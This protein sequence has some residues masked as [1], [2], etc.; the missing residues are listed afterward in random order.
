LFVNSFTCS[1]KKATNNRRRTIEEIRT[2]K[3]HKEIQLL[4]SSKKKTIRKSFG[5]RKGTI[6]AGKPMFVERCYRQVVE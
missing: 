2:G 5:T 6:L 4:G 3:Y 1:K